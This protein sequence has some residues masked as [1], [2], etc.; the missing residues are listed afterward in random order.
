MTT[1]MVIEYLRASAPERAYAIND[2]LVNGW[3][4][5]VLDGVLEMEAERAV[6][7]YPRLEIGDI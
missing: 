6:S 2:G 7:D 4:L 1:P 5:K 3:G